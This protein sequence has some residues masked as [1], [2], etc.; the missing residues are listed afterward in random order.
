[1]FNRA[2]L[3]RFKKAQ[4]IEPFSVSVNPVSKP[5]V[6][7]P[8]QHQQQSQPF[9][10]QVAQT[11]LQHQQQSNWQPPDWA[12][13]PKPGVFRLEVMKD[14][15]VLDQTNLDK[16]RHIFGRQFVTCDFVLDHPSVSRQ[17]AAVVQ[18]RNGRFASSTR[19]VTW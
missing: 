13:E 2:G 14:G 16:R 5:T 17:H 6:N 8:W 18:H 11:Q 12:L 19:E 10:S 15:E 4:T 3:D 7:Q 9:Q 1:M